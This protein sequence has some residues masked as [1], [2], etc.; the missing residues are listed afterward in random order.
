M[1]YLYLV[2]INISH[3]VKSVKPVFATHTFSGRGQT[4]CGV[5]VMYDNSG[6]GLGW[7]FAGPL[8][9]G[10]Y[11]NSLPE[12]V[13]QAINEHADEIHSEEELHAYADYI[14]KKM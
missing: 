5:I 2:E 6:F 4:K 8:R 13:Q 1:I 10:D 3:T 7:L 12:E 11:F 9:A 14:S